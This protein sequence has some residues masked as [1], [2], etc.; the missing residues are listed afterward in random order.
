[1][2]TVS[3]KVYGTLRGQGSKRHVGHG[4]M[5]ESSP[6]LQ[7]WRDRIVWAAR[8]ARGQQPPFDCPVVLTVDFYF[9]RPRSHYRTGRYAHVLRDDAPFWHTGRIDLD[10][11][12]RAVGDALTDAGVVIDDSRIAHIAAWK[13]YLSDRSII[14]VPG[15]VIDVRPL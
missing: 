7:P 13:T 8:D 1:M 5:I 14:D 6:H 3:F 11:A 4:V 12:L 2:S 10:K 15:A 9:A